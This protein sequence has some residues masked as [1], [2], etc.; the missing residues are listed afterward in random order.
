[1]RPPSTASP[2]TEPPPVRGAAATG[3]RD[4][5]AAGD[6]RLAPFRSRAGWQFG[7]L[8]PLLVVI[9]TGGIMLAGWTAIARDGVPVLEVDFRVFWA[10]ARLALEGA[11]GDAFEAARLSEIHG[12][13]GDYMPWLYPPALLAAMLPF[14]ALDFAPAW[15]LFG[16]VSLAAALAAFRPLCAGIVPLWLGISIAPAFLPALILGQVGVLWLAGLV[17]ALAALA[18]GRAALAGILIGL[19]TFKPQLGLLIPVALIAGGHW[20]TVVWATGTALAVAILPTLWTG[21]SYWPSLAEAVSLHAG[22]VEA[23]IAERP[24]MVG[25]YAT[26]AQ[27]GVAPGL[28]LRLHWAAALALALFVALVWRSRA[29]GPDLKAA[30]LLAAI[31]L[32]TPYL[33]HAEAGFAVGAAL[34]LLRAGAIGTGPGGLALFGALWLVPGL[35]FMAEFLGGGELLP[36]GLILTVLFAIAFGA[37]AHAVLRPPAPP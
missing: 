16:L 22:I 3:P 33:W 18:R 2:E 15:A 4:A 11:P 12:I 20:R 23:N 35:A 1:M 31:P 24:H 29:L 30:A 36:L 37:A 17:G 28:A 10:A 32:A 5:L 13:T 19:L 14:G 25:I 7:L 27:F 6:A 9:L 26:L 34:F 8:G 21:V